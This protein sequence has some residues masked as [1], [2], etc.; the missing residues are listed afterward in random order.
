MKRFLVLAALCGLLAGCHAEKAAPKVEAPKPKRISRVDTG[1]T[2]TTVSEMS[3][4]SNMTVKRLGK[5]A[6]IGCE[7]L[8]TDGKVG[9]GNEETRA[10]ARAAAQSEARKRAMEAFL[11]VDVE[12]GTLDFNHE[13][14]RNQEQLIESIIKT[15]RNGRVLDEKVVSEGYRD[16]PGCPGCQYQMRLRSC[17]VPLPSSS[18]KEFQVT[19]GMP[20]TNLREGEE[21]QIKVTATRDC[22]VYLYDVDMDGATSLIAPNEYVNEIHLKPGDTFLYPD[23]EL[24]KGRGIKL[25]AQLPEGKD[26]SAETIRLVATKVPLPK[27][28]QDPAMGG[29]LG[30]LRRLNSSRLDWTDTAEAFTIY[31]H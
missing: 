25:V 3:E 17:L 14:L 27:D 7:W 28:R 5:D 8:E 15:T 26:V 18:D 30:L 13:S 4:D 10:Q 6:I 31:K 29:Y 2:E 16:G 9:V 21:A 11:G 23:P 24:R 12:Q 20:A 19:V 1:Q 22:Y